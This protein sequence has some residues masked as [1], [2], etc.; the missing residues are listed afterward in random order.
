[1]WTILEEKSAEKALDKA[2]KEIVE[3]YEFWKNV[4]TSSGPEGLKQFSG[5]HDHA[6]TGLWSGSRSSYLNKKWRVIYTTIADKLQV[7]VLEVNAHD[8]R[9][10]R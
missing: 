7:L 6:L 5:F 3:K 10:K 2:P 4:I 1:M 8:Y 9:K